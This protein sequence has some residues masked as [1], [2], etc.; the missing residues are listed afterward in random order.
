MKYRPEF[1]E[2]FG[3]IEDARAF[4]QTFFPWYNTEHYYSGFGLPTPEN[5]HYGRAG[6]IIQVHTDVL[7]AAYARH[8]ELFKGRVPKTS[9][10]PGAVWINKPS[11]ASD[12]EL[13]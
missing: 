11:P 2:R 1:P 13:H 12:E 10:L 9:P 6:R 4:C 8:P 5:V 3:S 7:E